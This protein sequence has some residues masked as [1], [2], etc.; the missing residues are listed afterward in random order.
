[1][2]LLG[3]NTTMLTLMEDFFKHTETKYTAVL[4]SFLDARTADAVCR[5]L[6]GSVFRLAM[7]KPLGSAFKPKV[8]S[9]EMTADKLKTIELEWVRF[10]EDVHKP[11]DESM[12]QFSKA[13]VHHDH[14]VGS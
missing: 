4:A 11:P 6:R 2:K 1:M 14:A 9:G 7:N 8:K 10:V 5:A 13:L 3:A 12:W